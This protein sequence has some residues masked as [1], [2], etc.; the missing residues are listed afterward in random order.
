[1]DAILYKHERTRDT[2]IRAMEEEIIEEQTRVEGRYEEEIARFFVHNKEDGAEEDHVLED[3]RPLREMLREHCVRD[4]L[5]QRAF[6]WA[7]NLFQWAGR[8]YGKQ[9]SKNR[10]LFEIYLNVCLVPVKIACARADEAWEDPKTLPVVAKEYESALFYLVRMID[11][12]ARL[13][14]K[15]KSLS[16]SFIQEARFLQ[17]EL[18]R[19]HA[20]CVRQQKDRWNI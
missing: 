10:D 14:R 7:T 12:L 8:E 9:T 17:R 6:F 15:I 5:Y 2:S 4:P 20:Q 18:G 13:E 16:P 3:D 11:A 19:L 1:M